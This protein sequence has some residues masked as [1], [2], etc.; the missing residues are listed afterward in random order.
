[1]RAVAEHQPAELEAAVEVG[2][3]REGCRAA[4]S[5][6]SVATASE[7]PGAHRRGDQQRRQPHQ[8]GAPGLFRR[9]HPP[10]ANDD[11]LHAA[12]LGHGRVKSP[13]AVSAAAAGICRLQN[14]KEPV[15]VLRPGDTTGPCTL[16]KDYQNQ[17]SVRQVT[18]KNTEKPALC[19]LC[20]TTSVMQ[21]VPDS[22]K[23]VHLDRLD[24][25]SCDGWRPAAFLPPARTA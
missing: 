11:D 16:N 10:T 18:E 21:A 20:S 8:R 4:E 1:M 3:S 22:T 9:S 5:E 14:R 13:C 17:R 2:A 15:A 23:T 24:A 6:P 7:L 25:V 12:S 19:A